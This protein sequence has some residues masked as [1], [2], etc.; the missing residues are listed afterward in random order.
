LL[1]EGDNT[2]FLTYVHFF[3]KF[4]LKLF[5]LPATDS[6]KKPDLPQAAAFPLFPC[7]EEKERVNR[8]F[9]VSR[10]Y[11]QPGFCVAKGHNQQNVLA[12]ARTDT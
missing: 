9:I 11:R 2:S 8:T 5:D 3:L 7:G 6:A 10:L 4:S 1:I 12:V